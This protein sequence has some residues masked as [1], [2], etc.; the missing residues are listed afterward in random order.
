[1]ENISNIFFNI[2]SNVTANRSV[3][4]LDVIHDYCMNLDWRF[5]FLW[6]A[7]LIT[8]VSKIYIVRNIRKGKVTDEGWKKT[9]EFFDDMVDMMVLSLTIINIILI[10]S[11]MF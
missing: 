7:V 8:V 5:I 10:F 1:M 9:A 11:K 3:S 6:A 2:T 4:D